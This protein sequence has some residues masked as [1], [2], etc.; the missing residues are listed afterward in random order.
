MATRNSDGS[1]SK[2]SRQRGKLTAKD[3]ERA[4]TDRRAI[5]LRREDKTFEEI[6]T[7]L[8]MAGGRGT[9]HRA[10]ARGMQ[11]WAGEEVEE[12]R[13]FEMSRTDEILDHL[14]PLVTT[15]PPDLAA[16]DRMMRVLHYRARITGLY[17]PQRQLVDLQVDANVDLRALEAFELLQQRPELAAVIDA[18]LE[19]T[20]DHETSDSRT[21]DGEDGDGQ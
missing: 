7:V 5:E 16:I 15:D 13:A 11:R 19:A 17:A 12:L 10:V 1:G 20:R 6:A 9:A 21:S 2:R 8:G 3:L 4:E 14:S 18:T